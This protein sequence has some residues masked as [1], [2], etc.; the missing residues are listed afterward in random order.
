MTQKKPGRPAQAAPQI[1]DVTPQAAKLMR[2][3]Y[4]ALDQAAAQVQAER[5]ADLAEL[6]ELASRVG[7]IQALDLTRKFVASATLRLF[8]QVRE[9]KQ[10]KH[11]PIQMPDG[12]SR[13]CDSI[14]EA[15]PLI[16]GRSYDTMLREEE[17]LQTLGD[18]AY[19]IAQRLGL[20]RAALRTVRA[21]PAPQQELVR[22]AIASGTTKAEVLSV[23]EDLAEKAEKAEAQVAEL[24]AEKQTVEERSAEKTQQIEELQDKLH[25]IKKL[26]PD[27]RLKKLH[28]EADNWTHDATGK[29]LGNFRQSII[30]LQQSAEERGQPD[31]TPAA[32]IARVQAVLDALREEF[33]LP[34]VDL[35]RTQGDDFLDFLDA[36]D[37]KAAG[38]KA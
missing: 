21:L 33:G 6:C 32:M 30:A 34:V 1:K 15:C 13:T 38:G 22:A 25:L 4:P 28:Q 2:Q 36:E 9:S 3:D 20:N 26:P 12:T 24:Q 29:L 8:Q 5:Q 18:E 27:E 14:R 23:I 37:R 19:D 10:I 31:A 7:A 17:S 11:L 16:F 35:R